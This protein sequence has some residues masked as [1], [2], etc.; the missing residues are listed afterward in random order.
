M[1]D[2]GWRN[3]IWTSLKSQTATWFVGFLIAILTIFSSQLTES[4]K[5]GL[6]RADSRT[7][8]YEE[9]ASEISEYIFYAELSV[10][11]I[12]NNW[13]EK[14]TLEKIVGGYNQ[15]IITLRKKEFVYL[16]WLHKYWGEQ[17]VDRF[18]KFME[19]VKTF[20]ASIH[21]LNDEF[22]DVGRGRKLK[23]DPKRAEE[24]LKVMKPAADKMREEGRL[25]LR[26]LEAG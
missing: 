3:S 14:E 20:D 23:V 24:V 19:T 10:E 6:N 4:V 25:I 7:Q 9:L 21:S 16:A 26:S 18:E 15:S 22:G 17:E 12:E 1:A 11:F 13:T 2:P 5:F 8:Q